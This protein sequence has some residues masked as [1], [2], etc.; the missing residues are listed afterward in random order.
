MKQTRMQW[1]E[2]VGR[3]LTAHDP[4]TLIG[5]GISAVTV[6]VK[7]E[8]PARF[9]GAVTVVTVHVHP[10]AEEEAPVTFIGVAR[11]AAGDQ[12]S[13][14]KGREIALGRVIDQIKRMQKAKESRPPLKP[15]VIAPCPPPAPEVI[16]VAR[17]HV[18]GGL[19]EYGPVVQR[20]YRCDPPG[21]EKQTFT[22][23]DPAL[24]G[25]VAKI[26]ALEPTPGLTVP[27]KKPRKPRAKKAP[28]DPVRPSNPEDPGDVA[29]AKQ[30]NSA[31]E[32]DGPTLSRDT[33]ARLHAAGFAWG[34]NARAVAS[35]NEVAVT[36]ELDDLDDPAKSEN[37]VKTLGM[38]G[39]ERVSAP[40]DTATAKFPF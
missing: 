34:G 12:F 1:A 27:A 2:Y 15:V 5:Y 21:A 25:L 3:R 6:A 30:I 39:W 33:I 36:G 26:D 40:A 13:R 31:R 23:I 37:A 38:G 20:V 28:A 19:S 14:R 9:A 10:D 17:S 35:L 24:V 29:L 7:H 4:A 18:V 22:P 8:K 11:C 16:Q 32:Y